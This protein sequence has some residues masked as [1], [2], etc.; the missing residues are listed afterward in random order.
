MSIVE[1]VLNMNKVEFKYVEIYLHKLQTESSRYIVTE[2]TK[3]KANI[4]YHDE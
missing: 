4:N 1:N 3:I 2:E